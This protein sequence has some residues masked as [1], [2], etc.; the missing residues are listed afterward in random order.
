MHA[1][2]GIVRDG[3]VPGG[4]PGGRLAC[5][6]QGPPPSREGVPCYQGVRGVVLTGIVLAGSQRYSRLIAQ[7]RPDLGLVYEV[8]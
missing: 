8:G 2:P 1:V 7:Q 5:H 4:G 6:W 3:I